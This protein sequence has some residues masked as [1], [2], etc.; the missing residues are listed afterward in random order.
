MS[1]IEHKSNVE[2]N[3]HMQIF[4]YMVYIWER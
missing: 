3:V 2:Y 1:L 4:R